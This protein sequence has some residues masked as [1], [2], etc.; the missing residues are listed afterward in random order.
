M[1]LGRREARHQ[2]VAASKVAVDSTL[3]WDFKPGQAVMTIDGFPGV[4]T[5]VQDGPHAGNEAYEVTLD[6]GMGGGLYTSGQL[7][8]RAESTASLENTAAQDY[9]ELSEILV[10]R[11]DIAPNTVLASRVAH[12]TPGE[13]HDD[14][15]HED[16]QDALPGMPDP[17]HG[18]CEIC[19][20]G[21]HSTPEHVDH[22]DES[23][24]FITADRGKYHTSLD[25]KHLGAHDTY[26]EAEHHL[27]HAMDD[28]GYY[29]NVWHDPG[30]G[31]GPDM[32]GSDFHERF[33]KHFPDSGATGGPHPLPEA[34]QIHPT[35]EPVDEYVP[36]EKVLHHLSR[37]HDVPDDAISTLRRWGAPH[38]D[39][40]EMHAEA[41]C[42]R[43][44]C[45]WT[46][47]GHEHHERNPEHVGDVASQ[48]DAIMGDNPHVKNLL[49][50]NPHGPTKFSSKTASVM[51]AP[52]SPT[53][54]NPAMG[55][56]CKDCGYAHRDASPGSECLLC[57][58]QMSKHPEK[59]AA[60]IESPYRMLVVA[61][62]DDDFR[63]HITASWSDVRAKAKRLR[64]EGN[65]NVIAVGDNT[66]A[67]NVKGE[68]HVYETE[69]QR[70][71]G[72]QSIAMWHCGC[73]WSAYSWGRSGRWKRY[74]GRMCS[75]ALAL[76]YEAQSR[77]M[78]GGS[79]TEDQK[80]PEWLRPRTRVV[81]EYDRDDQKNV[82]RPAQPRKRDVNRTYRASLVPVE[83]SPVT[84]LV[85]E[86]METDVE[87][88]EIVLALTAAGID[89]QSWFHMAAGDQMPCKHCGH[90]EGLH[91]NDTGK[92]SAAGCDCGGFAK[93]AKGHHKKHHK[94]HGHP[95][96]YGPGWGYGGLVGLCS[97]CAGG[98]CGHCQGTGQADASGG[99]GDAGT[100]ST[101]GGDAGGSMSAGAAKTAAPVWTPPMELDQPGE[102]P[103]LDHPAV[104]NPGGAG[105]HRPVENPA[106]AGWASGEDPAGW[107]Q[108]SPFG[109]MGSLDMDES[110]FEPDT[111]TA[112]ADLE[113][114]AEF[115][116]EPEAALP[117][118][119]GTPG[120]ET[121]SDPELHL[122]EDMTS[123]GRVS[124]PRPEAEKDLLLAQSTD[125]I[126]AA[127]QRSAGHLQGG[128][129]QDSS[130][131]AAAAK[132]ALAKMAMKTFTPGEQAQ[133]ISEGADVVASNLD[134]LDIAG[135]HYEALEASLASLDDDDEEWMA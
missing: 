4:V 9:P 107:G 14:W 105:V 36:E 46:S 127:F 124:A 120:S 109:R 34:H 33:N 47:A 45:N 115:H 106:S 97:Q 1:T 62:T 44:G 126:V 101:G 51:P 118:T 77:G 70:V 68:H 94:H 119:D 3:W 81:T 130:D 27:H 86:A 57:G 26:S 24:A 85:I 113:S 131:I 15:D 13:E 123:E 116:P 125:Q 6:N 117:E 25:G 110:M 65:V 72:Q 112:L 92:C 76:Q 49:D 66:I 23:D 102:D 53:E 21:A 100:G 78:F 91:K 99:A 55:A 29:P 74:E 56:T 104:M 17:A 19:S 122:N 84:T 135:T 61:A 75:H 108:Q 59:Y 52:D 20:S 40:D 11:P 58:G 8:A 82:S 39:H 73:K 64:A 42:P 111:L 54:H 31:G 7:S 5:A 96:A 67:A 129:G 18:H 79:I 103:M 134:R 88:A 10:E 12:L 60:L 80:A 16:E 69:I 121:D 43:G 71:P 95:H 37:E 83:A 32:V 98:G 2:S 22:P 93:E 128:G 63:F 133:I 30:H 114:V 50:T 87:P 28:A 90:P 48:I 35:R 89:G 41:R 132:E 38:H